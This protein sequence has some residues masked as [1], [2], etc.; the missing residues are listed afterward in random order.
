MASIASHPS[1]SKLQQTTA[2]ERRKKLLLGELPPDFLRLAVPIAAGGVQQPRAPVSVVITDPALAAQHNLIQAQHAFYSFVPPNTRGRI[3]ITV[4]EAKLAKN[5]GLVRMDPYCRIRVGNAVFE[6][7]TNISGG[8]A[9]KWNRIVNAYLPHGVESIYLQIYDERAFTVDECIAW[10]HVVLPSAVFNGEIIDDWYQLSGQQGDGKEGAINLIVSFSPVETTPTAN[11]N[12][13]QPQPQNVPPPVLFTEEEVNELHVMF[14]SVD[15]DVI[16]CILEEKRGNKDATVGLVEKVVVREYRDGSPR[17]AL[18][19]FKDIE[20]VMHAMKYLHKMDVFGEQIFIHPLRYILITASIS[21]CFRAHQHR[22]MHTTNV[23]FPEGTTCAIEN[24]SVFDDSY[25]SR[26][27]HLTWHD[28][29]GKTIKNKITVPVAESSGHFH[30]KAADACSG[31]MKM[32][33][34]GDGV[35]NAAKEGSSTR[36]VTQPSENTSLSVPQVSMVPR[37]GRSKGGRLKVALQ[38]GR[39]I[40]DWVKLTSGRHIASK[41]LPFVGDAELKRHTTVDDCWVLLEDKVYDV[42][43]YLSFHPGGV[44]ELMRAAGCDGTRLFN[45]YHAW[46]NQ[47]TML[48]ACFVGYFRGDRNKQLLYRPCTIKEMRQATRNIYLYR[49]NMS[50]NTCFAL[51]VGHHV[52]LKINKNGFAF[53]IRCITM[54]EFIRPYTPVLLEESGRTISFLIKVYEDGKFSCALRR[55]KPGDILE[56]SDPIGTEDFVS[57]CLPELCILTAGTG[58]TPMLR[59]LAARKKDPNT[60]ASLMS[61][62]RTVEDRLEE[63]TYKYCGLEL[64]KDRVSLYHYESDDNDLSFL[65]IS[66]FIDKQKPKIMK[67]R[68]ESGAI[69]GYRVLICGP[70]GFVDTAQ[71]LAQLCFVN[72]SYVNNM[73]PSPEW[74]MDQYAVSLYPKWKAVRFNTT[75]ELELILLQRWD[76]VSFTEPMRFH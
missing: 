60:C 64:A 25:Y 45:K 57:A 72:G 74:R 52:N 23:A 68:E 49:M 66:S 38:P 1:S 44:D 9:P 55:L 36:D 35:D 17:N 12:A 13:Q 61:L 41:Q 2:A 19:V 51:P 16:R 67:E 76:V 32:N 39:G 7:P 34:S 15:V 70:K 43:E 71:R 53:V 3:S 33:V 6:T 31:D 40:M 22:D 29:T 58:I 59:L 37:S 30:G 11:P 50:H 14:P 20:S 65:M 42:T 24:Q 18:V 56:I 47:D 4:V 75:Q 28:L 27:K 26:P 10:A 69:D 63:E 8:K 21:R 54:V 62:S 5:Y 73:R 46:I 48:K